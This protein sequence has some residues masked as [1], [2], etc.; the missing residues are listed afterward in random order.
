MES[1]ILS[2]ILKV[3]KIKEHL[4][5]SVLGTAFLLFHFTAYLWYSG[6]YIIQINFILF[7]VFFEPINIIAI[8][9]FSLTQPLLDSSYEILYSICEIPKLENSQDLTMISTADLKNININNIQEHQQNSDNIEPQNTLDIIYK[10]S[11]VKFS[12]LRI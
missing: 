10:I 3:Y 11:L 5:L 6:L 8:I 1:F 9:R 2:Y 4:A 12:V 7:L